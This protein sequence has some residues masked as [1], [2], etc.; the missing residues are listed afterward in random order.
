MQLIGR[1]FHPGPRKTGYPCSSDQHTSVSRVSL[2]GQRSPQET[3]LS[4]KC[5]VEVGKQVEK[6]EQVSRPVWQLST[7]AESAVT[8]ES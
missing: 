1:R 3:I 6:A 4:R 2:T 5:R 8:H 7:K